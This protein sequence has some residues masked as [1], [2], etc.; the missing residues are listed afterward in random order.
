MMNRFDY[1]AQGVLESLWRKAA[2]K[3]ARK[4][5]EQGCRDRDDCVPF[6]GNLPRDIHHSFASSY[7]SGYRVGY[8]GIDD[9]PAF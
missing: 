5:F 4:G 3:A 7:A 1:I 6:N 2:N 8:C 9:E